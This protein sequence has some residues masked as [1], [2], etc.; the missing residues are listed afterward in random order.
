MIIR[1][2]IQTL[3]LT[4]CL[5]ILFAIVIIQTKRNSRM[6]LEKET[7]EAENRV[8]QQE[9]QEKIDLQEKL[10]EE[11]KKRA[12]QDNLITA[13]AS[14]YRSVYY[15]NLDNNDAVC[16]RGDPLDSDQTEEGIHFSFSDRFKYYAENHVAEEYRRRIS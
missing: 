6:I 3:I 16:Y 11:E 9:L 8:K 7:V 12:L 10:L 14:D 15:V 2:I 5:I 1:N 13:M 4:L